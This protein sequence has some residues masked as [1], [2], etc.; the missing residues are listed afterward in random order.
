MTPIANNERKLVVKDVF[1]GQILSSSN[2]SETEFYQIMKQKKITPSYVFDPF[3][4]SSELENEIL[5]LTYAQISTLCTNNIVYLPDAYF[6]Y[7]NRGD[8]VGLEGYANALDDRRRFY[9]GK[10]HDVLDLHVGIKDI[11]ALIM[12]YVR[13]EFI[14]DK[15]NRLLPR[16]SKFIS[17]D[18][19]IVVDQKTK[20][21]VFDRT[22][23]Y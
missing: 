14:A 16:I 12:D 4:G 8:I 3:H 9:E 21:F 18:K 22:I 13:A 1:S 20:D 10:Y 19:Y 11:S 2:A 7:R 17:F 5:K 6:Y 15:I 23:G